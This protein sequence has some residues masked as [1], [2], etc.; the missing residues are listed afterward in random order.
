L[1]DLNQ[2]ISISDLNLDLN[3]AIKNQ[4]NKLYCIFKVLYDL[5][6]TFN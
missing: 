3:Q 4:E 5:Y 1:I 6:D 2:I